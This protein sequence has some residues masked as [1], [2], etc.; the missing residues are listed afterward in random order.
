MWG[1]IERERKKDKCDFSGDEKI[2][3]IR[4]LDV[5]GRGIE[6]L[7][8]FQREWVCLRVTLCIWEGEC[9]GV[10]VCVCVREREREGEREMKLS[11][12]DCNI[13][14]FRHTCFRYSSILLQIF[15]LTLLSPICLRQKKMYEIIMKKL[16]YYKIVNMN[17]T[18]RQFSFSG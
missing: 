15:T 2:L 3:N 13:S 18:G 16:D 4:A 14:V 17:D 10:R 9:V 7:C 12:M 5:S 8:G 11:N 1:E 6:I